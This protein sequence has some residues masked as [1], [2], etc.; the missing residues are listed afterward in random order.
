MDN[1]RN[2]RARVRN[3]EKGVNAVELRESLRALAATILHIV[4]YETTEAEVI[5]ALKENR[6]LA[7]ELEKVLYKDYLCRQ[8]D[9]RIK[10]D[11]I[12]EA[13][14][15]IHDCCSPC[16]DPKCPWLHHAPEEFK[17][18]TL[19]AE[20]HEMLKDQIRNASQIKKTLGLTGVS[21]LQ[22]AMADIVKTHLLPPDTRSTPEKRPD[23]INAPF[24]TRGKAE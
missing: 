10:Q 23:W 14:K 24:I 13:N 6:R 3:K 15:A 9:Q 17:P 11:L 7:A 8:I 16:S 18:V 22:Q 5:A 12:D 20:D 2:N 1:D 19:S 4:Q 21:P